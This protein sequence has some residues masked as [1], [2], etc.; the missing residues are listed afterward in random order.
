MDI[1]ESRSGGLM[2]LISSNDERARLMDLSRLGV[3]SS[4]AFP[5]PVNCTSLSPD[6]R[7][8][9][10]VGDA[11]DTVIVDAQSGETLTTLTGHIDYSFACAWH[12][13]GRLLATGNQDMTTRIYDTRNLSKTLAV[14]SAQLGAIRSLRFSDCGRWL[15]AA[16]PAD[17]VH[18]Y[19]VER[20]RGVEGSGGGVGVTDTGWEFR[21]QMIDF[22]GEIS[23]VGFTPGGADE[24][25][26]G[27]TGG[28]RYLTAVSSLCGHE[29][30]IDFGI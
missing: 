4:F 26:V 8:L 11:T 10:V 5:W 29:I 1:E 12:P 23:G 20:G 6:R 2:A 18:V 19:D 21:E 30:R 14:L 15:C 25:F 13:S 7:M 17:F 24:L 22:F 16:E 9:A 27:N 3:E 28:F